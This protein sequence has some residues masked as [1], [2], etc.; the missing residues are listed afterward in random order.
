MLA[1]IATAVGTP[2][3][4]YDADAIRAAYARMDQAFDGYP[5]AI[6]YALKANSALAVVRL[7]KS[8]GSNADANS[9][10]E[11]DVAMRCGFGPDDIVFT[12][13]PFMSRRPVSIRLDG[14]TATFT[15]THL[16]SSNGTLLNGN[17]IAEIDLHEVP[18][19][20]VE[21]VVNLG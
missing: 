2:C 13:D 3:Y 17:T 15:M 1:D 18:G 19:V 14:A 16:D 11:V 5:H 6:H 20:Q 12:D 8:L 9:L 7:M 10:G 21:P 4:V